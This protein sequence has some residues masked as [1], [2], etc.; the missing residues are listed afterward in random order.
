M[1]HTCPRAPRKRWEKDLGKTFTDKEWEECLGMVKKISRNTR[2]KFTQFNYIHQAY[3][4]P[5][6]ITRM[7]GGTNRKCPRCTSNNPTFYHMVW[8]CRTIEALW[9]RIIEHINRTLHRGLTPDPAICLLGLIKRPSKKKAGNRM[10][11]LTLGV[12]RK[13]IARQWKNPIGP[14]YEDWFR[15]SERWAR[16]EGVAIAEEEALGIRKQP[17]SD[18]WGEVQQAF[19]LAK[20]GGPRSRTGI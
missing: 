2:L 18:T 4:D 10:I 7:F 15:E 8:Q 1:L 16:A 14:T 3:L 9:I 12:M 20:E 6:K 11:D 19:T 5:A 17:L 13:S